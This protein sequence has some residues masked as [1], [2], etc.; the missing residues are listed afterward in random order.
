MS[1]TCY[2]KQK[3]KC[4]PRQE[5]C[6]NLFTNKSTVFKNFLLLVTVR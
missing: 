1:S 6:L 2:C 3:A 4:T 5:N